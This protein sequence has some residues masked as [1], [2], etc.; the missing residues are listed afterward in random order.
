MGFVDRLERNIAKLEKRIE[1]EQSRS[2]NM[3]QKF[4][5]WT[6]ECEF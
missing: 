5:R 6:L 1:K 2:N 4:T 3:I